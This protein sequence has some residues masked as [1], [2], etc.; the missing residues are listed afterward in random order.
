MMEDESTVSAL[1]M[2]KDKAKHALSKKPQLIS[3]SLCYLLP[4]DWHKCH[5]TYLCSTGA[6]DNGCSHH[7]SLPVL[8]HAGASTPVVDVSIIVTGPYD[9]GPLNSPPTTTETTPHWTTNFACD[10]FMII[11]NKFE[12]RSKM[13]FIH[14]LGPDMAIKIL[15]PYQFLLVLGIDLLLK[16]ASTSNFDKKC[17]L[18]YPMLLITL[19]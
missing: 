7:W 6:D 13:D 12:V 3:Y 16:L 9:P 10:Q 18:K 5:S 8:L 4:S 17:F 14:L 1:D 15:T 19:R 11:G 2:Q